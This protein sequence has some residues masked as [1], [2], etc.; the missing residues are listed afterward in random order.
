MESIMNDIDTYFESTTDSEQIEKDLNSLYDYIDTK[1]DINK[2]LV[3]YDISS[4]EG[5]SLSYEIIDKY[6]KILIYR[7]ISFKKKFV[8][9]GIIDS[10][11]KITGLTWNL[12]FDKMCELVYYIDQCIKSF[13]RIK[14]ISDPLYSFVND[15]TSMYRFSPLKFDDATSYQRLL[16]YISNCLR[17]HDYRR[18]NENCYKKMYVNGNYTYYWQFVSSIKDF[19]YNNIDMNIA[20]ERWLDA[21]N[22]ANNITNAETYFINSKDKNFPDVVKSRNIFSFNNGIYLAEEDR[23]H[24]YNSGDIIENS[25]V[26]CSYFNK[27]ISQETLEKQWYDISTPNLQK[28]LDFQFND[29]ADYIDICKWMYILIGRMFYDVSDHDNWQILPYL[30]GLAG[31]GKSTILEILNM[32]YEKEDI[33]YLGNNVEKQFPLQAIED[34]FIFLSSELRDW[35]NMDQAT[36]QQMISGENVSVSK[37]FKTATAKRWKIPGI[38]ASNKEMTFQDSGGSISRRFVVFRFSKKVIEK[39]LG[40]LQKLKEEIPEIIIKC[41]KAYLE[42]VKIVNN[43]DIWTVMPRYFINTKES[44]SQDLDPIKSF[45]FGGRYAFDQSDECFIRDTD[46]KEQY[47]TYCRQNGIKNTTISTTVY[48]NIFA[49]I[50]AS[51]GVSCI[52]LKTSRKHNGRT[53]AGIWI[54]GIRELEDFINE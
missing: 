41:N 53:F 46:F 36:I 9:L 4:P 52:R 6:T 23:F 8:D 54:K 42:A 22:N 51:T 1:G 47:R 50:K 26:A 15:D 25:L 24:F 20:F 30:L 49:E 11:D 21:T 7:I 32:I 40:L 31:T 10:N 3:L 29:E 12:K 35:S 38:I 16:I 48:D 28:I 19:I 39:D 5:P 2:M 45:I 27:E 17:N 14:D 44:F 37:K 33:G 43:R 13:Q 18:Y 34:K